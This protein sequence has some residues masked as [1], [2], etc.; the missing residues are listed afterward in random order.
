MSFRNFKF[1]SL[2]IVPAT[3]WKLCHLQALSTTYQI[4]VMGNVQKILAYVNL[5]T[6]SIKRSYLKI[7]V[8][9]KMKLNR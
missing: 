8:R 2:L 5:R 7:K 1:K 6:Y 9:C 3:K 4:F